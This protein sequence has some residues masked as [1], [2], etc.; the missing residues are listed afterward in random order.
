MPLSVTICWVILRGVDWINE[1]IA[2]NKW[3][4]L[5]FH[6]IGESGWPEENLEALAAW[7][8]TQDILVVTQQQGLEL[9]S[10]PIID[11][12]IFNGCISEFCASHIH[13]TAHDPA[14]G[15]LTYTWESLDDGAIIGSGPDVVFDPAGPLS[16][17]G[18]NP[19]DIKVAVTSCVTGLSTSQTID[20]YVKI[21][22]DFNGDGNIDGSDL[23]VF[24]ADFGR[25]DC[26]G[27]CEGDFDNDRDVDGNDLAVFAADF[28]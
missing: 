28:G 10:V 6:H 3:L 23:A 27:D 19:Y 15:T 24:A 12:I 4:I 2:E 22:G 17:P 20:I 7:V 14:G 8:A 9:A 1:A 5:M 18:C 11:G 16:P 21:A 25:T 26:S 13:V